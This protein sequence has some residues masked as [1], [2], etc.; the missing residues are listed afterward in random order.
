MSTVTYLKPKTL[1]T[2][3][4]N[5]SIHTYHNEGH[6]PKDAQALS[7]GFESDRI[8]SRKSSIHVTSTLGYSASCS[9]TGY[10]N[11]SCFTLHA[12]F[13]E[14]ADVGSLSGGCGHVTTSLPAQDGEIVYC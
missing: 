3:A 14:T 8:A 6:F 4:H 7:Q 12:T 9:R 11:N 1:I 2:A 5:K 13:F 10:H